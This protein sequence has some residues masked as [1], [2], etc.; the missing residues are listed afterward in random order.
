MAYR[1]DAQAFELLSCSGC[2][3]YGNVSPTPSFARQHCSS[4]QAHLT[5]LCV[6]LV[7]SILRIRLLGLV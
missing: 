4:W 3:V 5:H 7:G 6:D 2:P 1:S